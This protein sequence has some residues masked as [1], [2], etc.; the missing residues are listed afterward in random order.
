MELPTKIVVS[1]SGTASCM[2]PTGVLPLPL[3]VAWIH[4]NHTIK[5]RSS[6]TLLSQTIDESPTVDTAPRYSP[7]YL[8]D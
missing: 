5:V 6:R 8:S 3:L 7:A 2:I 4:E 1:D